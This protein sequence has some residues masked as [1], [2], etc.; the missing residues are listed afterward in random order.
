MSKAIMWSKDF[1]PYCV[2]AK[3]LL[4]SKGIE[5]EERKLGAGWT[6]EQLLEAVPGAK[7]VPQIFIDGEY[8][9]G[10]DK[11]KEKYMKAQ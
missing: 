3:T 5:I 7:S 2:N 10:F 9:G 6:K 11:L 8:V 1:C 4:E